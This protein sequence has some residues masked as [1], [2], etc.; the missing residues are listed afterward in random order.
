MYKAFF[1][2]V[3]AL[4]LLELINNISNVIEKSQYNLFI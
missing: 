3:N 4:K 2:L 1:L